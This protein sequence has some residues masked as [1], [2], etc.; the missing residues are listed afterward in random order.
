M[1]VIDS[2][3]MQI[4]DQLS[5]T[6]NFRDVD[7]AHRTRVYA[8]R[9]TARFRDVEDLSVPLREAAMLALQFPGSFLPREPGETL[10]G[11]IVYPCVGISPEPCGFGW[12]FDFEGVRRWLSHP[13]CGEK[14]RT[15]W[16]TL[17]SFWQERV[18][19]AKCRAAYPE[20]IVSV[21]PSDK[22]TEEKGVGFPLYRI[23]GTVL[24]YEP[25]CRRG[26][27]GLE[28]ELTSADD[29]SVAGREVLSVFRSSLRFYGLEP[30]E[31]RPP[32]T[33]EEAIQLIWR[34][35]LHA[36][37]WNYGRL[38]VVLGPFLQRDL[39]NGTLTEEK[40]LDVLCEFW[41]II[42][43]YSNQYNNRIIIGGRGR[44]DEAA[45]DAF[46]LLAIEATRRV[47]LNQPQLSL[48]FY[49]GQNPSL[50]ERAITAIGEGCTFPMLYNDDI[51]IS[52]VAAAH[53]VTEE[54]AQGYMPFGC[55]EYVL[56]P[57]SVASPNGV[58]NL[59][60]ALED[61]LGDGEGFADFEEVWLAYQ[62]VVD[63]NVKALA[64]QQKIEYEVTARECSF[65]FTSLLSPGCVQKKAM[66]L[67]GGAWHLGGTL[68]SYGNINTANSLLTIRELVYVQK[69]FTLPKMVRALHANYVGH[70]ELLGH[71]RALV[72]YG[73][74]E[75]LSDEMASKVHQHICTVTR[76]QAARV[77]LDSYLVVSINNWANVVF[78]RHV[79]ASADGR[80]AGEAMANANNPAPGTDIRGVSAFLN[81]LST[82]DPSIHAG[83]VQN[84][85]FG[86][87]WFSGDARPKFEALL[88]TYFQRGGTQ[89]M[90]TVVSRDD[91]EAAI[92]EPEKWGHLMVRMW[93]F[94]IRFV[95]LPPDA[96]REVL[97]RTLH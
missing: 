92:R 78:G 9:F 42:C 66:L 53:G 84:M 43:A 73:N 25:L 90:V 52:A 34:W 68:E 86:K 27:D 58:I 30:L 44:S 19:H 11:R 2:D 21:L 3:I 62:A 5:S 48:R 37:S 6:H 63:R 67:S 7:A 22:W 94:S 35:S 18:T 70:E 74:D 65:I 76:K 64:R 93:G 60:K 87:E 36:G 79:G 81:S 15:E 83:A 1:D 89:A 95:E 49:R 91:L 59:L 45:A 8:K 47:R 85:K 97:A 96:Q 46:G 55:G 57:G 13:D 82:L 80:L 50:W 10:A 51:N 72:K 61:A 29:F 56:G 31:H 69:Q 32:Q 54:T 39:A 33:L 24:N 77:G 17:M 26:L 41:R 16:E 40:A 38:D 88:R 28:A 71:C 23:A 20:E 4:L 75:A 14:E 12:Y